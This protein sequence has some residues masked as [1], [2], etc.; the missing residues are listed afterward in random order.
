MMR[1][2]VPSLVGLAGLVLLAGCIESK[3]V[4]TVGKD[5]SGTVEQTVYFKGMPLPMA[6][7]KTPSSQEM[8]DAMRAQAAQTAQSMGEGVE[9]QSVEQLAPRDGWKGMRIVYAFSDIGKLRVGPVPEI[10]PGQLQMGGQGRSM[11]GFRP[12][13]AGP[14]AGP[15]PGAMPA[16]LGGKE[17]LRFDFTPEPT[18][19]LTLIMP[20]MTPPAGAGTPPAGQDPQAQAMAK[21]M[22]AQF[23]DGMLMEFRVK[24]DGQIT[25]TNAK[26]VSRDRQVVGL[27]RADFGALVK[28]SAALD[29]MLAMGQ[30]ATP[31][32]V[33]KQFQDPDVAGYIKVETQEQ[34][35]IAFE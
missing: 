33:E 29:K 23:L 5:G 13:G 30:A 9:V 15:A 10:N 24:V 12:G 7:Q 4:V 32:E 14:G 28:D 35:E 21:A 11:E 20:P 8:L 34:V 31:E 16:S 2:V 17:Q 27:L 3:T 22:M 6:G 25:S 26:Y 18:P 1:N 19:K